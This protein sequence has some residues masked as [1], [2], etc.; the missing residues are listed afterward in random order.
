[1]LPAV[2][3]WNE[4]VNAE[5]QKAVAQAFGHPG[6]RAGPVLR[7]FVRSL[8]V[9]WRLRDLGLSRED[10]PGVAAR[11][12]GTGPIATNPRPVKSSSDIVEILELAW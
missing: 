9:P 7:E 6:Q 12:D 8:G 11:Y 4:P 1:M 2:M 5:R 10:L 3:E